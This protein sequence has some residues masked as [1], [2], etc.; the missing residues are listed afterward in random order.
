MSP[1]WPPNQSSLL[2]ITVLPRPTYHPPWLSYLLGG[3]LAYHSILLPVCKYPRWK[4]FVK[5]AHGSVAR[6]QH[7]AWQ[8]I[9]TQQIFLRS[10]SQLGSTGWFASPLWVSICSY[11]A[12]VKW[13]GVDFWLLVT[14]ADA[15]QGMSNDSLRALGSEQKLEGSWHLG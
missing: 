13:D 3:L 10:S 7:S 11:H 6:T 15:G 8:D 2:S 9:G 5:V 12:E 4:D 14:T 1:V